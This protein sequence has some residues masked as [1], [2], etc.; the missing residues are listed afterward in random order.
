MSETTQ[1]FWEIDVLRGVAIIMM[2]LYH[3]LFDLT[4]FHIYQI[5]LGSLPLRL[6]LYPIGTLFLLLVGV[7]LTISYTR[8]YEHMSAHQL[9]W[10]FILRG[11][12]IF[13]GGMVITLATWLYIR[14]GYIIFGVLHCIGL[15]I[16]LAYPLIEQ[17]FSSLFL[18]IVCIV[19]GIYLQ[20]MVTVGFPWLLWLGFIPQ[21][22]Y[23]LDYFPLLPWFGVV[24]VGIFLGHTFYTSS[25]RKFSLPDYSDKKTVR[26]VSFLGRHSLLIYFIHQPILLGLL[27]LL[28]GAR[29]F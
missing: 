22:F 13:S 14:D 16:I 10:K 6:F 11:L 27:A 19:S 4:F 21:N 1:R 8:A 26:S 23:T 15:S 7:S 25:T 17:R 2:I 9:R 24:L 3:L 5:D 12:F 29:I 18:G 20:A 28:A